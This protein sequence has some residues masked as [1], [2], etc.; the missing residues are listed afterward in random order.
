M[1]RLRPA[2]GKY[3]INVRS[4]LI[5][6]RHHH[7]NIA[8]FQLRV[9][10]EP[11]QNLIIQPLNFAQRA[12]GT[13]KTHAAIVCRHHLFKSTAV[14]R[15]FGKRALLRII[16]IENIVLQVLQQINRLA[17]NVGFDIGHIFRTLFSSFMHQCKKIPPQPSPG[18]Q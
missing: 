2:A 10:I 8:R 3:R 5:D 1:L 9:V 4:I 14:H 7:H 17:L 11:I 15:F 12:V 18:G 13:D 6:I 16:Q